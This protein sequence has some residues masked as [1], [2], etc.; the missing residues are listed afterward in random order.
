MLPAKK[1]PGLTRLVLASSAGT[2]IEYYD[3]LLYG[4]L[5]AVFAVL[6]F[7]TGNAT[8]SLLVSVA[9]FGVGFVARPLG[10][11]FFGRI[12]D[13]F[14]R[15]RTMIMT[16][17]L[18]GLCTTMIGLLP[19]YAQIGVVAPLLLVVL[20]LLQGMGIGGEYSA[21]A[22]YVAEHVEPR[23]RGFYTSFLN[24]VPDIGFSIAIMV[25][26]IGRLWLG[27]AAFRDWGWRVAF[28]ISILL[29]GLALYV[30]RHMDESPEF[31]AINA[32]GRTS[33]APVVETF[34]TRESWRGILL[35]TFGIVAGNTVNWFT[36]HI[37]VLILLQSALKVDFVT[38]SLC[39]VAAMLISVPFYPIAGAL[40]DRFGRAFI[41]RLGMVA[42]AIVYLPAFWAI[43]QLVSQGNF[44]GVT[45]VIS[46]MTI[47]AAMTQGPFTAFLL[48]SFPTRIR[49]TGSGVAFT[50]GNVLFG[51]FM[52]LIGLSLVAWTGSMFGGLLYS[53]PVLLLSAFVNWQFCAPVE[54]ARLDMDE[55]TTESPAGIAVQS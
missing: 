52:P 11:I 54:Q 35:G 45:A 26:L 47:L 9:T 51:G 16:L 30:R 19:T 2:L 23:R 5:A 39:M 27:A 44:V 34:T 4:S 24:G 46:V 50:L 15:K 43:R 55:I 14:G 7:P 6:F 37:F 17:S 53:I 36:S 8:V 40:S 20:R 41:V 28:V 25:V 10:S 49:Y 18:M 33:N 1:Q 3:F 48:D 31:E 12:G 21:A 42:A 38:A 32:A 22:V 29:V 13:R